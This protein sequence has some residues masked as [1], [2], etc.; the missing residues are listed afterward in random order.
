LIKS[1]GP[2]RESLVVL[3]A[4]VA[5]Y[6]LLRHSE[7]FL[8]GA[9]NDDGAYAMLG[10]A[11]ADGSGY[12]LT[13]LPGDP[14][15][16]KYPP[17]LPALL[18]IPWALGGTLAAVRAMVGIL[19]PLVCGLAAALIWWTGRRHLGLSPAIIAV[20]ALGP[21]FLD[22]AIQYYN[23]PLSE[24]YFLLGWA[25]ALALASSTTS[26]AGALA[27]GVVLAVTS[28]FR[29]AGLVLIPACLAA[30][31]VR[32]VP[33][34]LVGVCAVTA[35]APLVVWGIVHGRMIAVGPLSSAPDEVSYWS[36]IPFGPT[37]LPAYLV[38]VLWNNSRTY[39]SVLSGM[40][41][42]P[43][44]VG[45]LLVTG[46][47][48]AAAFGAAWSWRRAP[49]VALTTA[50]SLALVL[51]WPF[52]QDRLLL[53]VI[54]FIGLLAG[55]GIEEA[56]RR[57]PARFRLGPAVLLTLAALIIGFRQMEL[58]RVATASFSNGQAPGAREASILFVLAVNSRHIG[59]LS[60]WAR[61]NTLPQD[62]LLVD[63]PAATHLY[64]GR[65]TAPA[66]PSES[67]YAPSVFQ[68]TG[69][70]LA[71]RILDDSISVVA[72]GILGPLTRDIETVKRVCSLVLMQLVES[73]RFY[74][75]NRDDACLRRLAPP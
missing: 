5:G 32:R 25:A 24:P 19:N 37:E 11:I 51:V 33:W 68:P 6:F 27:L 59:A 57:L 8:V 71:S 34:R 7:L 74:R 35:V 22:S 46:A 61:T 29:S 39:F 67:P 15:A 38:T 36:W 40:F 54:P 26:L 20:A 55:F 43:V 60:G 42:G 17:G 30:L 10:K 66:S 52:P 31:A 13:Y 44:I 47:F 65:V 62:R 63:F 56:A 21:L 45:H 12:R 48:I 1:E 9:F 75:V 69:R 14:V 18:A 23:I 41:A 3:I 72:I 58:R 4:V 70:Y 49:A 53:P 28:L 2:A 64:S 73:V 50:A 16:V